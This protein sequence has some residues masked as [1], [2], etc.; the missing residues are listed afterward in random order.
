METIHTQFSWEHKFWSQRVSLKSVIYKNIEDGRGA[1]EL[2]AK[3]LNDQ[4]ASND[5]YLIFLVRQCLNQKVNPE[6]LNAL[7]SKLITLKNPK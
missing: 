1:I 5:D 3:S 2:L 6:V 4:L 7:M